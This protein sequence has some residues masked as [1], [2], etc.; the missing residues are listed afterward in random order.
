MLLSMAFVLMLGATDA[1]A[2]YIN[3]WLVAGTFDNAPDNAGFEFDWIDETRVQ[4]REGDVS[5]GCEWRYFDDRLFSRNYDDYQ[6]LFSYFLVKRNESIRAKVVYAC[7]YVYT[8][9]DQHAQLRVG[10]DNEFKAWLNEALVS[11]STESLPERDMSS[12]SVE[13]KAGWNRLLFKIANQEEGRLGF[14]ARLCG[15]NGSRL[16][17]LTYALSPGEGPLTVSTKALSGI[18]TGE[19]PTAW[20]EWSYVGAHHTQTKTWPPMETQFLRKPSIA[21]QASDFTLSAS[22]GMPPYRWTLVNGSLPEGLE[23]HEDGSFTGAPAKNAGLSDYAIRVRV[24][25]NANATAEKDFTLTLR[26][27][28]NKWV[29]EARLTA[30]IHHP[31]SMPPGAFDEFAQL[32]KQ[33]NYGL[34]MVISYNN[35]EYKY[36]WPS[37]F[38]PGNP[39]GIL[40]GRYKA[41]LEKAGVK[42]GMYIGNIDGPNHN[43]PNGAILLV[44]DAIRSYSPKA[45]WF[46]WAGWDATSPDAIYSM[47]KSYDPNTVVILNGIPTM[48]NGDWDIIDLE[49][50][51]C[52]GDRLWDLWPFNFPWPKKNAVE[53]WRL[54]VDPAFEYSKGIEPDWQAYMRLQIALIADG[55]I[56]NID[57]SPTLV[58]GIGSDGKLPSLDESPLMAV[59]RKMANWA[60][61]AGLPP[62]HESYT[63]VNPGP[64]RSAAWGY[65]TI[66]VPRNAV[67]LHIMSTPDGK[68]GIPKDGSLVAEP[69]AQRAVSITCMNTGKPVPFVQNDRELKLDV[70][71]IDPDPIDTILKVELAGPHPDVEAP[72]NT[73]V[74]A[75]PEGNLA[76]RKPGLLLGVS[77]DHTLPASAFHFA[78][79]ANDGIRS[80]FACG[81]NE[82]AWMYHL[83]LE[84]E[85]QVSRIVI[86]FAGHAPDVPGYPT[87][88]KVHLSRDGQSWSCIAHE[89]QCKGGSF[90]Y[91]VE[92]SPIRYIRVEAVTPNGPDQE[93]VQ[94]CIAEL[95]AYES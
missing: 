83:D 90:E 73:D 67:Y 63:Q 51:G 32:M 49:G 80:T 16:P 59:H 10:A 31:E 87:E 25:D 20:R 21:M 13:L 46:D 28:P 72:Q 33:Q 77:G 39:E 38:E 15:D 34:G 69:L 57:H 4:P 29:E 17:G 91:R 18:S 79:Y 22:G 86:H 58:T 75:V 95:E 82:Y 27:R 43:G 50:W 64:L 5:A 41:A 68:A 76:W 2:P 14:Y 47:I 92:P 40:I 37:R 1:P 44:E 88:Y 66:N 6:D 60:N 55:H 36:R 84:S 93:G 65:N 45:F 12:A 71:A 78:H 7:V 53:T 24:T 62:L 48:S 11:S 70:S 74:R 81:A 56:A 94:M 35:G 54:I 26:E 8:A 19:L 85:K 9:V 42:F 52:W 89:T 61:P 3:T 23:L 30:L